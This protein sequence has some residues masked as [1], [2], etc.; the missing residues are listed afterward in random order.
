MT[1]KNHSATNTYQK[2]QTVC[3]VP[4]SGSFM[5]TIHGVVTSITATQVGVKRPDK[6]CEIRYYAADGRPVSKY[7]Q[8]QYPLYRLKPMPEQ[9]QE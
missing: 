1:Q 7:D 9:G 3:L 2:G 5:P 8:Q 4:E 6:L